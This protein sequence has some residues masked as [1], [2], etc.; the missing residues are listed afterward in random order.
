MEQK[1]RSFVYMVRCGDDSLYTGITKDIRQRMYDHYHK[2]EKGAKYTRSRRIT[3]IEMVWEAESYS[4]AARLEYAIKRLQR[5]EKLK[6]IK[7]PEKELKNLFPHLQE[8]TYMP[9]REYIMDITKLLQTAGTE[10]R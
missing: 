3:G 5:K 9:H 10:N 8:E 4:S 6:L 1:K 2:T 7:E